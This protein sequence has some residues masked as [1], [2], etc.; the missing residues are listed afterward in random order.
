MRTYALSILT[1]LFV[2]LPGMAVAEAPRPNILYIYLDDFGWGAL[3]PNGQWDRKENNQPYLITPALDQLVQE[4]VNFQ[5]AYGC[6]VC[7]PARA[8]Q[9]TGFHQGHAYAD[10]NDPDNARKAMR[11]DDVTMGDVLSEAGYTTGFWGKWGFGASEAQNNPVLQ[12]LQTL[13]NNH[14]YQHILAELHHVRAHTFFQPT[15]WKFDSG[16]SQI[17]LSP[18]SLSAYQNNANYPEYPSQ[19]NDPAYPSTAY[20]DDSYAFAALDFVRQN[21]QVYNNTKKPFFALF[22]VQIPH[23]PYGDISSL[24]KWDE[25][26]AQTNFFAGLGSNEKQYAAMVTRIDAHIGNL[27][28]ALE[29]PNNDGDTSDSVADNTIVIFQS[30][31][32]GQNGLM[33][34]NAYLRGAKGSIWEGGIRV[35]LLVRWPAKIKAGASLEPGTSNSKVI[36]VTDFLPTF[37]ELAGQTTPLG[38]DGV[39]IASFL[40]GSDTSRTRDYVIHEAGSSS[41]II[42]GDMKFV[43]SGSSRYLY[44]LGTDLTESNNLVGSSQAM[45]DLANE[46][47]ALL[48]AESVTEPQWYAATYHS[49]TGNDNETTSDAAHW[50][51]YIYQDLG[52]VYD[53]D[54]GAPKLS[55]IARM[56]NSSA[57]PKAAVVDSDLAFLALQISGSSASQSLNLGQYTLTSRNE[58]RIGENGKIVLDNGTI[59]TARWV[60]LLKDGAISGSGTITGSLYHSGT[61]A[62]SPSSPTVIPT[63]GTDLIQ[64]ASFEDG[65]GTGSR[66]YADIDNWSTNSPDSDLNGAVNNS[67]HTGTYRG[68]LFGGTNNR[69]LYQNTGTLI[70]IN[71]TFTL[72]FWHRGFGSWSTGEE[73]KASIYYMDEA[74]AVTLYES[75]MAVT[76]DIWNQFSADIPAISDNNAVGKAIHVSFSPA[77]G[78]SGYASIDDVSLLKTSDSETTTTPG[79]NKLTIAKNLICMPSASTSITIA[80]KDSAGTDYSQIQVTGDAELAGSLSTEIDPEF[81]PANGDTFTI[82]TAESITGKYAHA[83][84][85]ITS[86]GLS[87]KISYNAQSVVLTKIATTSKGTPHSWLDDNSLNDGD[88]EIADNEDTDHDG[89]PNW[90]E[91]IS[92]TDP[93]SPTSVIGTIIQPSVSSDGLSLSW[94]MKPNRLYYVESSTDLSNF[95]TLEG[96]FVGEATTYIYEIPPSLDDNRFYRVR[97]ERQ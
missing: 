79:A 81:T 62:V 22:S 36:D 83:D 60:D 88:Y 10:R 46:L 21:G 26:Y 2:S 89:I 76:A 66:A 17:Y 63:G 65:N 47:E 41:S 96:P 9:Q 13:P 1:F 74:S 58:L 54:T 85:I 11:S 35:P 44:N 57:T 33:G 80:G 75:T 16:D 78:A 7:S 6:T 31:N 38:I 48:L 23:T 39:S 50:S 77:N 68:L 45:D 37:A 28:A 27:L 69:D 32:G 30:D 97:V 14:G 73:I 51:D 95:T 53:S 91:F 72:S 43:R 24:P 55:W 86:G 56:E 25:P 18:N 92:G 19:L 20:C 40:S 3:G 4:G 5:R 71:D 64:N 94:E 90:K 52:G 67:A 93:N 34:Q 12:N 61:L 87:F 15:L 59:D 29:D 49:W 84:D 8:S 70:A 82:L 42:R